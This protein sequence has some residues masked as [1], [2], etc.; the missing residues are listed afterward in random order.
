MFYAYFCIWESEFESW[1]ENGW[2][3]VKDDLDGSKALVER[4]HAKVDW[5]GLGGTKAV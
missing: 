5:D 2:M 1:G 4:A 3:V